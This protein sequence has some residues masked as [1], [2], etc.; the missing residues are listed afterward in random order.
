MIGFIKGTFAIVICHNEN[1]KT[2]N[3]I[4]S[5]IQCWKVIIG[6]FVF[7]HKP[8]GYLNKDKDKT[9]ALLTVMAIKNKLE[10]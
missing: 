2:S 10:A 4:Q 7:K 9:I 8:F 3:N 6:E 5:N 1:V